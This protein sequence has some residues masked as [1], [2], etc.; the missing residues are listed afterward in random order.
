MFFNW[1]DG[2][3]YH[4]VLCGLW[5]GYLGATGVG[6]EHWSKDRDSGSRHRSGA[7]YTL[8]YLPQSL[9]AA[10]DKQIDRNQTDK[11]VHISQ[12]FRAIAIVYLIHSPLPFRTFMFSFFQRNI[13]LTPGSWEC[14]LLGNPALFRCHSQFFV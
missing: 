5:L 7:S 11:H 2:M 3:I 9:Y 8:T 1:D 6:S 10:L 14:L 13:F 4:N 12:A